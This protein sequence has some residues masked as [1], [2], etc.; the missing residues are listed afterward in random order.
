M[1]ST[2]LSPLEILNLLSALFV[3]RGHGRAASLGTV[4]TSMGPRARNQRNS[5]QRRE[6]VS[7]EKARSESTAEMI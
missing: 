4:A 2:S 6:R 3:S 1:P 5:K 7:T